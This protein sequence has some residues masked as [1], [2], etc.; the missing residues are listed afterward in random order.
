MNQQHKSHQKQTIHDEFA[1]FA[2]LGRQKWP[3]ECE[4]YVY[5]CK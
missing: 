2:K 1:M 4:K 3:K 5:V